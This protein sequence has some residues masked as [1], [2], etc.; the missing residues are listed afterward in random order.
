MG[1]I[2]VRLLVGKREGKRPL[3]RRRHKRV[4]N[5]EMD[6]SGYVGVD[7]IG[8]AQIFVISMWPTIEMDVT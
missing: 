3:G 4:D 2:D 6:L 5:I 8:L 7:W 1:E